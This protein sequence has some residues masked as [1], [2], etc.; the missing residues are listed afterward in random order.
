SVMMVI[1]GACLLGF[2]VGMNGPT[3]MAW[4]VDL[5]KVENRGRAVAS[6]YIAL[7][8][9]IGLGAIISGW[10]YQN[11]LDNIKY[12][13]LLTGLLALLSMLLLVSWR[14]KEKRHRMLKEEAIYD[15]NE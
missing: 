4:T 14:K 15:F 11:K 12:A 6:V 7:E 9:G 13:F 2:S 8:M 10:I 1:I 5:C 3:L